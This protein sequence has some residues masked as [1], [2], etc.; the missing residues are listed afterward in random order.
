MKASDAAPEHT[1]LKMIVLEICVR[2]FGS[3]W[4]RVPCGAL[5][6]PDRMSARLELLLNEF[7]CGVAVGEERERIV[8]T[9]DRVIVERAKRPL[10]QLRLLATAELRT[11]A[12]RLG[13]SSN[14]GGPSQPLATSAQPPTHAR[15]LGIEVLN[16]CAESSRFEPLSNPAGSTHTVTCSGSMTSGCWTSLMCTRRLDH[17]ELRVRD[18]E[19]LALVDEV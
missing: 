18:E 12:R 15:T 19:H 17:L 3:S 7:Q 11:R 16:A 1:S 9:E 10:L 6:P 14:T 13:D 4:R 5:P 8:A 2:A